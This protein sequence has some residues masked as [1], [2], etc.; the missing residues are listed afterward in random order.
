MSGS[1]T[2]RGGLSLSSLSKSDWDVARAKARRG[3]KKHGDEE[4]EGKEEE[5]EN[6]KTLLFVWQAGTGDGLRGDFRW[7]CK[8]LLPHTIEWPE[9]ITK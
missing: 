9:S 2:E 1:M 8:G 6:T 4:G 7:G 5:E 3:E